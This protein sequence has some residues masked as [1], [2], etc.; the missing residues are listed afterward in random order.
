[1]IQRLNGDSPPSYMIAP[2]WCL[3]KARILNAIAAELLRRDSWQGR[4]WRPAAVL[5]RAASWP[6]SL[7]VSSAG[8]L[9]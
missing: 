9:Q 3:E 6:M 7:P 4:A 2:M 5:Q 8:A 1:V